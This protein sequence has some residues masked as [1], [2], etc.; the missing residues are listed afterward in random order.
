MQEH[1]FERVGSTEKIPLGARI[2]AASNR[3][4]QSMVQSGEFREDLYFRLAVST[5]QVPPLRE[6]RADIP[7]LV[8]KLLARI[9]GEMKTEVQGIDDTA[10]TRLTSYD[11]PGNV[12]ELE[13]V[14]SRAVALARG[15]VL[16][17][18]DLVFQ[19]AQTNVPAHPNEI[20]PLREA[21]QMYVEKALLAFGWNITHTAEAL[22]ISPTTL[23]KKIA[24][25]RLSPPQ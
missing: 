5:I 2:V 20:G 18:D 4:L 22:E 21:E 3:D 24:D 12:R 15:R 23:R 11:W 13:N 17:A 9:A 25:Y 10:M 19:F 16:H 1:E 7:L 8:R 14:L 6:R